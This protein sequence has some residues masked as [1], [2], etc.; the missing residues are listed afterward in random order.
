MD[1]V[2]GVIIGV[3]V[4][5]V[6]VVVHELGHALSARRHGVVVEEFGIGFPPRARAWRRA[7]SLLGRNVEY[8]INWLPLGGF[9]KLKGEHDAD[10]GE[11]D[12]GAASFWQKTQILLMG[13]LM[14][15]A[16]AAVLLMILAW[17]GMPRILPDQFVM[18]GDTRTTGTDVRIARAVDGMPAQGAGLREGDIIHTIAGQAV[19]TPARGTAL[20]AEHSGERVEVEYERDGERRA[21]DINLRGDNSDKRGYL[22]ASLT[23]EEKLY[24][25]WSAPI[26]GIV[27]TGQFV[28]ATFHGLGDMV[29]NAVSGLV[30]KLIPDQ[31]T[32][33]QADQKLS[34]AGEGV[35]GPIGIFG[36]L[37]PGA[38]KVGVT[39]VLMLGAIISVGLAVLN[40]LP[41]PAL[42]GG[43]WAVMALYRLM[44]R[45]LTAE[46]E[47]QIHGTGMMLLLGLMVLV[48]I[49]D[50]GRF[51]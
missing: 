31:S 38:A 34:R 1:I 25:T 4:L 48:S 30:M 45:P 19:D 23:N 32:Q 33:Q 13:V 9:V 15:V 14:N 2:I 26:V 20:V 39:A 7:K 47:E 44:R 3:L 42:D 37:F 27:T 51:F 5:T 10:R 12:Y 22:G 24:S 50:V 8:S 35:T 6:L 36:V 43:R 11:G 49:G 17:I 40:V 28:V 18:P 29:G 46:R 21:I 16:A 41:V